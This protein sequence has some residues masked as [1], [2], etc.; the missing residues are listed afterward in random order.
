MP[1]EPVNSLAPRQVPSGTGSWVKFAYLFGLNDL[2][3]VKRRC[4]N[5]SFARHHNSHLNVHPD[6]QETDDIRLQHC[7]RRFKFR[8]RRAIAPEE[9]P[10]P[11]RPDIDG[12]CRMITRRATG[13]LLAST[14]VLAVSGALRPGFADQEIK[15]GIDL[16][17][18]GADWKARSAF[19]TVPNW[20][21][22]MRTPGM[23][24]PATP[25]RQWSMMTERQPRGSTIL[26]RPPP[27]RDGW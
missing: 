22:T 16:S 19:S 15:V 7:S 8:P 12:R 4:K 2:R 20:R 10:A 26:R 3:D 13:Q 17:L 5:K 21:S 25:S 1:P 27:M 18:T 23:P 24:F 6:A 14:A 11:T 9:H